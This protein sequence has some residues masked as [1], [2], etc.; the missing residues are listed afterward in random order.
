MFKY[1][2]Y[3]FGQFCVN[4]LS[5]RTAYRI[6]MLLSDL[7]YL[8]SPRDCRAVHHNLQAIAHN[9]DNLHKRSREVFRNFGKY[10]VE[11]FRMSQEVNQDFIK[12]HVKVS[13]LDRLE[14]VLQRGKG[15]IILTAHIGNWELGG[16]ILSTLG[17]PS[18]AIALPH[19]ERPVNDLF[20]RQRE[21]RGM[22]IVQINQAVRRCLETLRDNKLVAVLA[23]RDFTASGEVINFLG[24]DTL[25]P[26]GAAI[27]AA[28]T[29]AGIIPTF[30]VREGEDQFHLF[31]EE[32]IYPPQECEGEVTLEVL[33]PI[34]KKYAAVIE[35]KVRQYPTQWLM[36]REFWVKNNTRPA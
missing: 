16:V 11:F 27:F 1:Y 33:V 6:A 24:R 9:S 26:K 32:P 22:L 34:I 4:R 21:S 28:K 14:Q 2:L 29:G 7:H 20:N 3:K 5:L 19:K 12:Q 18:M 30:L 25:I 35:E 8:W 15:G 23:D 17:Y 13:N 36:F 10:L 31:L